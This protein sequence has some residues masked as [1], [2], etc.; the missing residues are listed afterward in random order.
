MKCEGA[1]EI[2]GMPLGVGP[3]M[4]IVAMGHLAEKAR[5]MLEDGM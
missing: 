2:G 4:M 1:R 5:A 3:Q